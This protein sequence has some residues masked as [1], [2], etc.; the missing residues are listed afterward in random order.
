MLLCFF[1]FCSLCLLLIVSHL[2][3][4][5]IKFWC[6][7]CT[8]TF[9]VSLCLSIGNT[10]F[11]FLHLCPYAIRRM[12]LLVSCSCCY[13]WHLLLFWIASL[14]I[15]SQPRCCCYSWLLPSPIQ[16][17]PGGCDCRCSRFWS[18][19]GDPMVMDF[20]FVLFFVLGSKEMS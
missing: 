5:V 19:C 11:L 16:A 8:L 20:L 2:R 14:Q 13:C 17:T 4:L 7:P 10:V 1:G 6:Y 18:G 15:R 3:S 9:L 12:L